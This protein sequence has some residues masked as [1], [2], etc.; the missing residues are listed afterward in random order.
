VTKPLSVTTC[1]N[2]ENG[3]RRKEEEGVCEDGR[4][5]EL[6]QNRDHCQAVTSVLKPCVLLAEN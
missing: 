6:A 5:E 1:K 4:W 2:K 3:E